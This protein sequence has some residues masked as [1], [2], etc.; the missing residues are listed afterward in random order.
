M[1]TF[2]TTYHVESSC[3][4]AFVAWLRE[5]Y[6]PVAMKQGVLSEPR[7]ARIMTTEEQ[8][9]VSLSLQFFVADLDVLSRWYEECGAGLLESMQQKFAQQVAGFS[10]LMEHIDL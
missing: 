6:I 9:G 10:T 5:E 7:M 4:D 8:E 3:Y 1:L 2:N